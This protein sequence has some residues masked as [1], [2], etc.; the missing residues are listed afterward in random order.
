[1]MADVTAVKGYPSLVPRPSHRPVLITWSM[2]K[3]GG[4]PGIFYHV[5]DVSVYLGRQRGE[6]SPIERTHFL[7]AFFTSRKFETPAFGAETTR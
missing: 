2:Q 7:H 5:N 3:Q 6:G 4:R 1:M